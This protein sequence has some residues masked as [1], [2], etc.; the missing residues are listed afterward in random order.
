[1]AAVTP[2]LHARLLSLLLLLS[3]VSPA[4]ADPGRA[5]DP[6]WRA[7]AILVVKS[8][9]RLYLLRDGQAVRSYPIA[10]G[11]SPVGPKRQ[12]YD[13]RTPEGRYV[14][15]GRRPNSHYFKALHVSYPNEDDR[16]QAAERRVAPGGDIMIHGLPNA[17][18]KPLSYYQSQD[19]TNGCIAL[20]NED[21][22]DLWAR[23][24]ARIPIEIRP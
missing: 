14:I 22:L 19:W 21:L 2:S 9:H 5:A 18:Q 8:E 13:F 24:P 17:P 20:S 23:V 1:M 16:R 6:T 3:T 7:D 10:L 12:E 15:D 11:L 4:S